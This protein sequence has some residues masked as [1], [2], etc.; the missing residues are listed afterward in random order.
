MNKTMPSK[1]TRI[2]LDDKR[3]I[4][5]RPRLNTETGSISA[6]IL[7]CQCMYWATHVGNPFWKFMQPCQHS[8]YRSGDSWMEELG[9]SRT[10]LETA[11]KK[12]GQKVNRKVDYDA[13]AFVW[14]WTDMSR[15]TWY[16][17][18]WDRVNRAVDKVYGDV[19]QESCN[20]YFGNPELHKAGIPHYIKQESCISNIEQRVPETNTRVSSSSVAEQEGKQDRHPALRDDDDDFLVDLLDLGLSRE[21]GMDVIGKYPMKVIEQKAKDVLKGLADGR[22]KNLAGYAV[23]CFSGELYPPKQ[24]EQI[25]R[26]AKVVAKSATPEQIRSEVS[27]T[28]PEWTDDALSEWVALISRDNKLLAKIWKERGLESNLVKLSF[29]EYLNNKTEVKR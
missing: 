16:E 28:L 14:Y 17:V 11:W 10:E 2:I 23:K 15:L 8:Q 24:I 13:E 19:M 21:L 20:T 6:T 1:D 7:L 18:N 9:M 4:S 5:Y 22:I 3:I 29:R 12:I 25:C 26:E 27:I